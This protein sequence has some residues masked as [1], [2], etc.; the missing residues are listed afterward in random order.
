MPPGPSRATSVF[1]NEDKLYWRK[2]A[3]KGGCTN[4]EVR[5]LNS[6]YVP[7]GWL[8]NQLTG[9]WK[10]FARDVRSDGT[11][12]FVTPAAEIVEDADGYHFAFEMPGLNADSLD[13]RVE[14]G[15]LVVAAERRRPE[16]SKDARVHASEHSYGKI[17]RTFRLP[18]DA[19]HEAS[20]ATYRDGIL[21][22]M[23]PKRPESK[24]V[25]IKVSSN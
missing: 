15:N 19:S 23:I 5:L 9:L 4:M 7:D 14:D 22:V 18:E 25:R 6:G 10:D 20:K 1:Q 17:R 8:A 12:D 13:V 21:S 2:G 16:W 3:G 11:T 24:P